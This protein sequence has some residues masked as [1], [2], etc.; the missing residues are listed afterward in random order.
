MPVEQLPLINPADSPA[1][2]AD[3]AHHGIQEG[4]TEALR[5]SGTFIETVENGVS[6]GGGKGI[7]CID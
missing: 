1:N 7:F 6:L 3:V 5:Y 2:Q 4:T